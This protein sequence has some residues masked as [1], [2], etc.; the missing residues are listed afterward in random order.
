VSTR[1]CT[2]AAP[3]FP[4]Q[5]CRVAQ[6]ARQSPRSP[7]P[8][9]FV[10]LWLCFFLVLPLSGSHHCH[11]TAKFGLWSRPVSFDVFL[12][13]RN[14]LRFGPPLRLLV[15]VVFGHS[16]V[17]HAVSVFRSRYCSRRRP[18]ALICLFGFFFRK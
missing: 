16:F 14:R 12:C 5:C 13:G 10:A 18:K 15:L 3:F 1:D 17:R 6:S 11:N 8:P 4:Q 9:V 2:A 7:T